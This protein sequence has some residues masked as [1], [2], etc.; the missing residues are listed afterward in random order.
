MDD[1]Q[2]YFKAFPEFAISKK[3]D[4]VASLKKYS[5]KRFYIKRENSNTYIRSAFLG[6]KTTDVSLALVVEG[7]TS[8][9]NGF[10]ACLNE[11][12]GSDNVKFI[13]VEHSSVPASN[14]VIVE[15]YT[16]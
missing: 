15:G 11:V 7:T 4:S 1:L 14:I 2:D 5:M 16:K 6:E 13:A 3:F 12:H 9:A 10:A 8:F